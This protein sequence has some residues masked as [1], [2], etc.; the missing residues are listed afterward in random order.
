MLAL[1]SFEEQRAGVEL[2]DDLPN[3]SGH[4]ASLC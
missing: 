4:L 2:A 1:G 3:Y